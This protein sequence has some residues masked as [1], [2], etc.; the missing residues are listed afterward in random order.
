MAL[1]AEK[2]AELEAANGGEVLVL[3]G[4]PK[5]W[6]VDKTPPWEIVLRKATRGQYKMWRAATKRSDPDAQENLVIGICVYPERAV[7]D[8]L[9][10]KYPSIPEAIS[11][12]LGEWVGMAAE[13]VGKG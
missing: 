11:E 2:I 4:K 6:D 10:D 5:S 9:L 12:Q 7:L 8:A 3:R 1:T 13:Q